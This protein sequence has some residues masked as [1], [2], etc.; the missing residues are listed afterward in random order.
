MTAHIPHIHSA[1]MA[2]CSDI[3]VLDVLHKCETIRGDMIDIISEM[4]EYLGDCDMKRLSMGDLVTKERQDSA[5]RHV[6]CG[7][8]PFLCLFPVLLVG[9]VCLTS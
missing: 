9:T 6:I 3:V 7:N 8:T 1:E 4:M 5:K 2:Q